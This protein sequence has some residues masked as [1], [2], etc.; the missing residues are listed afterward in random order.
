MEIST[1]HR[2][3]IAMVEKDVSVSSK[4][5]LENE[6]IHGVRVIQPERCLSALSAR[7]PAPHGQHRDVVELV[8][9]GAVLLQARLD[10][11]EEGGRGESGSL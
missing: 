7:G 6:F 2:E 11:A 10:V 1:E 5:C 8:D 3:R 4:I 9:A